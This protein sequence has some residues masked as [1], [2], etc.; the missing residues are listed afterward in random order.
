MELPSEIIRYIYRLLLRSTLDDIEDDD[1]MLI[2]IEKPNAM[3]RLLGR[4]EKY[5]SVNNIE[6]YIK[7]LTM[8]SL[9]TNVNVL[10]Y[11]G[12]SIFHLLVRSAIFHGY[13][14]LDNILKSLCKCGVDPNKKDYKGNTIT[15]KLVA[16][17]CKNEFGYRFANF[18]L[19]LLINLGISLKS[20]KN[21]DGKTPIQLGEGIILSEYLDKIIL[22][23]YQSLLLNL[24]TFE[25]FIMSSKVYKMA[26]NNGGLY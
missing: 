5:I 22:S 1:F 26:S 2:N 17:L 20:I 11:K 12:R 18:T 4:K 23:H 15:H 8:K 3:W 14:V 6:W 16:M 24:T 19:L 7:L 21:N 13:P 10:S 9:H 25:N